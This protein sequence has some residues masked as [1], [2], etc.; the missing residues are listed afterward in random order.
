MLAYQV[1]GTHAQMGGPS[2][3]MERVSKNPTIAV[4]M[5]ELADALQSRE[6]VSFKVLPHFEDT[7]LCLHA[8][9]HIREILTAVEWLT[10]TQRAPFQSGSLAI[11]NR[12]AELLFVT[13]D[14]S[15]GY[16]DRIAYRDYGISPSRFHWQTQNSAGP[17]DA[18]GRRYGE[19]ADKGW[20]FL[21][22]VRTRKG[23][24]YL[25]CGAVVLES[26]EGDRPMNIVWVF[27][28]PLPAKWFREFSLLRGG[29]R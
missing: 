8:G 13:L 2:A 9:Y 22:F 3:F 10:A 19:S 17:D 6:G 29:E 1:D 4:E 28:Q 23:E 7:P 5:V 26:I 18:S 24:P 21:L 25:A 20:H 16:H 14:K 11:H 12:K 27:E 15:A